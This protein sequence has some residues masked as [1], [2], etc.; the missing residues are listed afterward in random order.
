MD[1]E[2]PS[3]FIDEDGSPLDLDN[4]HN[5]WQKKSY[6]GEV[7]ISTVWIGIANE[8]YETMVF[9]WVNKDEIQLRYETREQ[10]EKGHRKVLYEVMGVHVLRNKEWRVF[11]S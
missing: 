7:M 2:Y 8:R 3:G 9:D 4:W 10:A 6:V 5:R 1:I 11:E